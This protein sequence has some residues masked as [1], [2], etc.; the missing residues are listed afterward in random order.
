MCR[1]ERLSQNADQQST[2][3]TEGWRITSIMSPETALF[4]NGVNGQTGKKNYVRLQRV[5]FFFQIAQKRVALARNSG[6]EQ[7]RSSPK[8]VSFAHIWPKEAGAEVLGVKR[9]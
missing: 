2:R 5:I 3:R 6:T 9:H 7:L 1:T 4:L 8:V